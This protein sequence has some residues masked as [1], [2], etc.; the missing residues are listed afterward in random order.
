M[1]NQAEEKHEGSMFLSGKQSNSW[2]NCGCSLVV[3]I[4]LLEL[5]SKILESNDF[6]VII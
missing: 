6:V 2:S 1:N 4:V 3:V 5:E